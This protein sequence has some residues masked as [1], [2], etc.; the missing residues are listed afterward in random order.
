MRQ[1]TGTR[2][3]RRGKRRLPFMPVPATPDRS[4]PPHALVDQAFPTSKMQAL[5]AVQFALLL[6][7]A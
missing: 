4:A 6:D 5:E 7:P 1:A 2:S 3:C